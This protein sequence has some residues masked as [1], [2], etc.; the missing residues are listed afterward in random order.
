MSAKLERK[1][2]YESSARGFLH[3]QLLE[4]PPRQALTGQPLSQQ[5]VIVTGSN[6]GLG[7]ES[8][9][10]LLQLGVSKLIMAVRSKAKGDA[11][12][13][14]LREE[15]SKTSTSCTIDVWVLDM[16][17]YA[18]IKAFVARCDTELTRIDIVLLNAGFR[19][20]EFQ[21]HAET[22]H[23]MGLQVNYFG[24][25]L[26][27]ALLVPILKS[28]KAALP[29]GVAPRLCCV[30]SDTAY[31]AKVDY[32]KPLVEQVDDEKSFA[33]LTCYPKTKLLILM[34]ITELS[35]RVDSDDVL[36]SCTNPGL[37]K[38][39]SF[40]SGTGNP[41]IDFLAGGVMRLLA[42]SVEIG[43]ST[44]INSV[45]VQGKESHGSFT[46]DWTIKP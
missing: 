41:V 45:V 16:A 7:Y 18:S 24:T 11:A 10:Q 5:T 36:I 30:A 42:R 4:H 8:C 32:D 14:Q 1:A 27:S 13:S 6:V 35:K 37:T 39:T 3:R 46:S 17:S 28:K 19:A 15:M 40:N 29:A 2:A 31:M 21:R 23:E 26:L 20:S 12:A 44:Y 38:G 22:G 25:A 33:A 34:F 9:R 43:A